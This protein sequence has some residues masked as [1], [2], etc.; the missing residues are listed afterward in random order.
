MNS[1]LTSVPSRSAQVRGFLKQNNLRAWIAWRPDELLMLS[2][3]FPYWGASLLVYFADAEPILFV[4]QLEPRDHIPAGLR[5]QEYPWGDLKCSDPYAE[6]TS[7]IRRALGKENIRPERVGMLSASA[8]TTLPIQAAEQI[9]IP[10]NFAARLSVVASTPN[11]TSLAAF[12][13]LYLRKTPS[14]VDAIR[15]ANRVANVG[16][17][18][19]HESLHPGVRE[20]DIAAAVESEIYQPNRQ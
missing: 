2:G 3:Y 4:P 12:A 10:E 14:E 17:Q 8:R 13:S 1:S 7:A 20:A 15:R 6:L 9:P 18:A 11:P 5:V 16:L 19:F